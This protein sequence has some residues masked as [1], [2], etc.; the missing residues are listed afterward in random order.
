MTEERNVEYRNAA[1]IWIKWRLSF[2]PPEHWRI[3]L[4]QKPEHLT[5]AEC[6]DLSGEGW[7][8]SPDWG[9]DEDALEAIIQCADDL[10]ESLQMHGR[11]A[12]D[13]TIRS[14]GMG[15]LLFVE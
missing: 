10:D 9:Y 15:Y 1:G 4:A 2:R 3:A 7:Q 13:C 6:F 14:D 12:V 5:L 11:R 8:P